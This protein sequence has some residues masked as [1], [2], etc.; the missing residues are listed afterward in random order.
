MT[1]GDDDGL[2]VPPAIAPQQVV[3]LPMLRENESDGPLLAYCEQLR[4]LLAAQSAMGEPVR[5][6]LDKKPGK[7]ANKRWDWVRKGAPVI[8][9]VGGRDMENGVVSQL[10]RDRLWGESGKP[11]FTAPS[12]EECA[13]AIGAVLAEI[14]QTLYAEAR[15]RRD[16]NIT[17][18]VTR[19]DELE[20]FYAEEQRY[21]GW[22][23][24]QWSKPSGAA[25]DKVVEQLKALKLTIRNVPMD[26]APADGACI[27]TGEPA[28]ERIYVARAY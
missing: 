23:E 7:A 22:V 19:M 28:V 24:V 10:R 26:A 1:H 18:G 5:V 13:A 17:R 4:R 9:E 25:L 27:F 14:Q 3:I 16:T 21:P 2:R 8:L 15:E 11:D 12:R 6:L 20:T